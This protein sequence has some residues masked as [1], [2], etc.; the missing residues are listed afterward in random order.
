VCYR[1][2]IKLIDGALSYNKDYFCS[3]DCLKKHLIRNLISFKI[4]YKLKLKL[5]VKWPISADE[6]VDDFENEFPR[7]RYPPCVLEIIEPIIEEYKKEIFLEM[8]K[9]FELTEQ[10]YEAFEVYYN[11]GLIDDARR[12][13]TTGKWS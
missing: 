4:W 12:C 6:F 9:H 11:L 10:Y 13:F 5:D 1:C 7:K 8:A 2:L 3:S